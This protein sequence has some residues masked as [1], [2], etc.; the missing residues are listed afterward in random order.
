MYNNS[1]SPTLRNL[2]ITSNS[3]GSSGGGMRNYLSFATLSNISFT[4]NSASSGGGLSKENGNCILTDVAFIGDSAYNG[5][6]MEIPENLPLPMFRLLPIRQIIF[7]GGLHNS[8]NANN[9]QCYIYFHFA[10]WRGVECITPVSPILTNV[11]FNSNSSTSTGGVGKGGGM[12]ASG[13]PVL[14]HVYFSNNSASYGGGISNEGAGPTITDVVLNS[15]YAEYFGGGINN[16]DSDPVIKNV[17]FINNYSG[18]T[19]GALY[20]DGGGHTSTITN[21]TFEGNYINSTSANGG[22]IYIYQ[23]TFNLNNSIF[24]Q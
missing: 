16:Y 14:N 17:V 9:E 5:G 19:G 15:N 18:Q 24:L 2:L 7:G 21:C 23:G 1:S 10:T 13:Y 20:Y 6:G 4:D 22:G 8:G 3:A 11:V 12:H